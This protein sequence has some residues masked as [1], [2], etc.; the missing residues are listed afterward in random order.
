[1]LIKAFIIA[2][3]A[4][5]GQKDKAGKA[6][7]LH[8]VFVA[9]HTKGIK[10]KTVALLHDVVEDTEITFDD[11]KRKGFDDEIVRAVQAITK[12]K[13]EN[14]QDYL[15]RVKQNTIAKDVKLA[16][17]KH[18]SDLHRIK[19]VTESDIIRNQKY[20]AAILYLSTA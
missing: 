5:R 11:L 10:R 3:K 17:L 7:I 13:G 12:I 16:D 4:H 14:Y 2:Y 15:Q 8:P 18:N 19:K 6:Y 20:Q 9:M 1:M